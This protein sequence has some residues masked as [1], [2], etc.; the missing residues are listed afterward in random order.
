MF[1]PSRLVFE[2]FEEKFEVKVESIEHADGLEFKHVKKVVGIE[3]QI[4]TGDIMTGWEIIASLPLEE[5]TDSEIAFSRFQ[6]MFMAVWVDH[7][8]VET[9]CCLYRWNGE[10]WEVTE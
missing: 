6:K 9:L 1:R 10:S 7:P 2:K 8:F 3:T 4:Q 5:Q